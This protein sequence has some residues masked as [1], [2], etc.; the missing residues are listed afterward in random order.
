MHYQLGV[1]VQNG[2]FAPCHTYSLDG[3]SLYDIAI[4]REDPY[5]QGTGIASTRTVQDTSPEMSGVERVVCVGT[6]RGSP[7]HP[8]PSTKSREEHRVIGASCDRSSQN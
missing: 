2:T 3:V 4:I 8:K 6:V 5:R 1:P 7:G